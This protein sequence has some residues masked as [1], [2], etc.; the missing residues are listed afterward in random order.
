MLLIWAPSFTFY[1]QKVDP[2][3][4]CGRRI[5]LVSRLDLGVLDDFQ[6]VKLHL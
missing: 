6:I 1:W 4:P 3:G 5:N 2:P